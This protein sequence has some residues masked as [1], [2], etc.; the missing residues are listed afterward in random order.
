MPEL[1]G[2]EVQAD[3]ESVMSSREQRASAVVLA[4]VMVGSIR[5]AGSVRRARLLS[6]NLEQ[7][8]HV[9]TV[10]ATFAELC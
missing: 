7:K 4:W 10:I 1:V 9:R 5:A 3:A 2:S 6:R 8:V